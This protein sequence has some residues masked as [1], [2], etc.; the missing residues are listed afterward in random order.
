MGT[1]GGS[2]L[3]DKPH[4][5]L[6]DKHGMLI[7]KVIESDETPK[8]AKRKL[9][10]RRGFGVK[11]PK[12]DPYARLDDDVL[13]FLTLKSHKKKMPYK[14]MRS[15]SGFIG[16]GEIKFAYICRRLERKGKIRLHRRNGRM[17]QI[18]VL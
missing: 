11:K 14:E 8:V 7:I 10:V 5:K 2:K 6:F 17:A 1:K 12:R 18:E 3:L 16:V 4:E 9:N 13:N 15:Y